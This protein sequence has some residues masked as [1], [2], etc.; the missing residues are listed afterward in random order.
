MD[1]GHTFDGFKAISMKYA[2][3]FG[4]LLSATFLF[5]Q[6]G[7][8]YEIQLIPVEAPGFPALH[9]YAFGQHGGKWLIIGGRKDGIH[10]RQPFASFPQ[11]H[12]NTTIYV[13]DP[14]SRQFWAASLGTLPDS[15]QEQLQATNMNFHQDGNTLYIIGGYAF[16]ARAGTHITFP[17]LT[18]VDVPGLMDAIITQKSI[19][20]FFRQIRD[21]V[22]AV[23]GGHL[24]K[25]GDTFYLIGGHRFDGRYNPH[26]P[27]HGPGFS[28][29]YTNQIRK[30]TLHEV[31]GALRYANYDTLT[32]PVHLRRRDYNLLPQVFPDGTPGYT[33]YSGV[34]Q[35]QADLPFLYPVDISAGG[36]QPVPGFNQYLSNYH[37]ACAALYDSLENQMH[38]LFFGGISQYYYKDGQMVQ[39]NLVPFVRTISLV[40]RYADGTLREFQLPVEMPGF[41]GASA[42]FIPNA[43]LPH[44]VHEVIKL[45]AIQEDT[46]VIGHIYGGIQSPL[47][48]PFQTN[49]TSNTSADASI[50]AVRLVRKQAVGLREIPG[51]NAFAVKVFP[52]PAKSEINLAYELPYNGRVHFF[53]ATMDGK[54]IQ[55]GRWDNQTAGTNKQT[56]RLERDSSSQP[57]VLTL[58]FDNKYYAVEKVLRK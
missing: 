44:Y 31:G 33:I 3:V 2:F 13:I 29:Q 8:D 45:S 18:A 58:V 40:T 24:G 16:S 41:K 46:F 49:Q 30:F 34:F 27:D 47:L 22:F 7:F 42:E 54:M 56:I 23:T 36:Y 10:A 53:L 38:S 39:D 20:P 15:L 6:D 9:S 52:N 1:K 37:S 12:N 32:D 50:Y 28:Q 25:L 14:D 5:S 19:A 4:I 55:S 57:L 48:N 43:E 51:K 21:D 17:R 35:I 26:G 11:A